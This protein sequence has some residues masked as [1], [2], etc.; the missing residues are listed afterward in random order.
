MEQFVLVGS[1]GRGEGEVIQETCAVHGWT[2]PE[3]LCESHRPN[4]TYF[5]SIHKTYIA[6]LL[7]MK[8]LK[9]SAAL[10][11]RRE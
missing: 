8:V 9:P 5:H 4:P 2:I 11:K 10:V 3:G 7:G 6:S 1:R